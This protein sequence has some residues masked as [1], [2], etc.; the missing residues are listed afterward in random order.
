MIIKGQSN[1]NVSLFFLTVG[2]FAKKKKNICDLASQVDC[3]LDS[4]AQRW[5]LKKRPVIYFMLF[6][7]GKVGVSIL[8]A[9]E[10]V[11]Q[12]A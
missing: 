1:T 4:I 8:P 6:F 12:N 10:I 2:L 3:S 11:R 9:S 7:L 5:I